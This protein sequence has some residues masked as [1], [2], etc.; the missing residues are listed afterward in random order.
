MSRFIRNSYLGMVYLFLYV[1]I[2]V[3]VCFS[4]NDSQYSLLWHGFSFRWYQV[5]FHDADMGIVVMH[6]FILGVGAATIGTFLGL[7]AAINL[8]RYQFFGKKIM[9]LMIFLMI[10]M[11]DLIFG[12]SML[13]LYGVA[14]MPLGFFSLLIA[15]VTFCLPFACVTISNQLKQLDPHMIEASR[16]LGATEWYMYTRLI[17]P[18]VKPALIA[19]WVLGFTLS[20]DDVVISYFV[21]GPSFEILPLHIFS[22][23]K[24]GVSPEINALSTL[25]LV[26]TVVSVL[27]AQARLRWKS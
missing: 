26:F 21:S 4:F 15:H 27:I 12:I 14:S 20:I 22:M 2:I 17:L 8:Y 11:P 13:L 10:I 3:V 5:L 23:V 1:P 7:I 6:S 19:S 18:L 9:S 25:L 16:D 24:M